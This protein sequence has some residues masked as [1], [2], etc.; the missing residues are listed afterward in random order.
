MSWIT[1]HNFCNIFIRYAILASANRI[2]NPTDCFLFSTSVQKLEDIAEDSRCITSVNFFYDKNI[3]LVRMCI[4]RTENV[5]KRARSE[6]V[7]YLLI[8][9]INNGEDL[10]NKIC[11]CI[12]RMENKPF[13]NCTFSAVFMLDSPTFA[14]RLCR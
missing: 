1:V 5:C 9:R 3:L 7:C 11:V 6:L 4:C 2:C 13:D 8:F 14:L 12:I 10:P